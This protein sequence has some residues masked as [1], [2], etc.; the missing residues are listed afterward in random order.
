M[1]IGNHPFPGS[2]Q[3]HRKKIGKHYVFVNFT[4]VLNCCL[5]TLS[6]FNYPSEGESVCFRKQAFLYGIVI[7]T[8]DKSVRTKPLKSWSKY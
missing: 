5:G 6:Q 8:A 3:G 7:D 4:L 2:F 1:A